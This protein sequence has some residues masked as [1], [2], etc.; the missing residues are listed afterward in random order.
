MTKKQWKKRAKKWKE[1]AIERKRKLKDCEKRA[2]MWQ[3]QQ[4][5]C[6]GDLSGCRKMLQDCEKDLEDCEEE[7]DPLPDP[8]PDPD[9]DPILDK[10]LT[11]E[12]GKILY[13]G[14]AIKLCGVSRWEA[15]WRET[16]EHDPAG[17]WGKYSLEWYE[18]KLIE[19]GINYVRHGGIRNSNLLYDHC[20]RMK[21]AGIIVEITAFRA[22]KDSKGVLVTQ[23]DMGELAKLGNVIF[24]IN[25]EFLDGPDSNI[26]KAIEIAK[27]LKSQGCIVSG[28]AWSGVN[29]KRQ[30]NLFLNYYQD[31]DIIT[32]HRDWNVDSFRETLSYGKPVLFNE[33]FAMKSNMSLVEVKNLMRL[34]FDCGI[35]GIQGVQYYGF[36]FD[37]IPGLSQYDPFDY[38]KILDYAGGLVK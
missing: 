18:N 33:F 34:A 16:G 35:R 20:K 6:L 27:N 36:R 1:R 26:D 3:R 37:G 9:P 4:L 24:D 28:G 32:H 21:K 12:N 2:N 19:S 5:D 29:G 30:A 7:P 38:Q 8:D 31:L 22:H 23:E 17:D 14:K 25:N 10:K 15:L 13:G 11:V